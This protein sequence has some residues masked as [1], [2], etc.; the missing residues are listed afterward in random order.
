MGRVADTCSACRKDR[1]KEGKPARPLSRLPIEITQDKL[2]QKK[3]LPLRLCK[4]CDG[5]A[6]EEAMKAHL[7]RSE[8]T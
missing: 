6:Y 8:Q 7:S 4:Y 1:E 2:F 5:D 3:G